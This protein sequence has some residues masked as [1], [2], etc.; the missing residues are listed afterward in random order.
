MSLCIYILFLQDGCYYI[1][2]TYKDPSVRFEEHKNGQGCKWTSIHPP[3]HIVDI[4]YGVDHFD[5]DKYT[6]QYMKLYGIEKVRG[7]AYTTIK[8]QT[9]T[10]SLLQ[11]ELNS[12]S[13]HCFICN[14]EGHFAN[15]CKS[16]AKYITKRKNNTLSINNTKQVKTKRKCTTS[17]VQ[18]SDQKYD[19]RAFGNQAYGKRRDTVCGRC[20]RNTHTKIQ[21]HASTHLNGTKLQGCKRCGKQ[22]HNHLKCYAKL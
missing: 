6:K 22:G 15:E 7:G 3:I 9:A 4:I 19:K 14:N 1:G 2:K 10:V 12:A 8:L 11:K 5:E 20:G 21:C 18:Q 13:D 17:T 16:K